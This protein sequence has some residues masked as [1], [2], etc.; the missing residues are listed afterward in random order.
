MRATRRFWLEWLGVFLACAAACAYFQFQ[1]PFLPEEDCYYH[2][3]FAWLVRQ[4]WWP[5]SGFQWAYFSF[6]RDGF[7]DG[8][9]LFHLLLVPFTFGDLALGGKSAGVLLSAFA[10]SSFYAI[11]AL[12]GVRTR[13]Y[14]FWLLLMGG[15]FFWLRILD[16]RPQVLSVAL[17][18]WSLHFLLAGRRRAFAALSFVYPLSYV[19]AFLP[20]V[21][22]AVRWAYARALG[23]RGEGWMLAWGLSGYALATLA[24]PYFPKNL[25]FFYVQ[26]VYTMWLAVVSD[27]QLSQGVE[28][29]SM[30]ARQLGT[31]H[32]PL[33]LHLTVLAF[34]FMH[35][36]PPLSE[37]TRTLFPIVLLVA[38]M[39]GMVSRFIEYAVPVATLFCAFLAEDVLAGLSLD[40]PA[41]G[42]RRWLVFAWAAAVAVGSFTATTT[43]R[44]MMANDVWGPRFEVLSRALAQVPDNAMVYTCNWDEP[45]ELMYYAHRLRYPAMF[46]P[47]FMYYWDAAL[48]KKSSDVANGRLRPD[49]TV[50]ALK[51]DFGAHY[52]LCSSSFQNLRAL[53]VRDP[54]FRIIAEDSNGFVFRLP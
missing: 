48:W 40:V 18:M 31:A 2:I 30:S 19:A 35:R 1:T 46:D 41:P 22:A 53:I 28:L 26:N 12:N 9:P 15:R 20:Q 8:E 14:W 13:L 50:R 54:R 47:A 24:H 44:T 37:R 51:E 39:A 49:E 6:L 29:N 25:R 33:L 3:K 42:R 36:R 11:L 16:V 32:L 34:V 52:G 5:R 7:S 21:F 38:A 4:H 27:V 43:I 17:L 23:R 10:L 45:A